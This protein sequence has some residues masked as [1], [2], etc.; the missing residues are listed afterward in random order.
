MTTPEIVAP[1]FIIGCHRSGTSI[2]Y[3]K[4]ALHPDLAFITRTTRRAPNRLLMMRLF[5]LLRSKEKNNMPIG[6]EVWNIFGSTDDQ[7]MT[8][9][10]V[11]P[12]IR[13]YFERLV[14]NHLVLFKRQRFFNK[15]PS[16]SVKIGFLNALF[17]DACF[18]HMVRDGR[19]VARSISK[20]RKSHGRFS[21]AKIPGW[22]GLLDRPVVESCGLQWKQTIEYIK[23]SLKKIP[24]G[25]VL[26]VR[27][28]D[29]IS[30]PIDTMRRVGE[31]CHLEWTDP[32]LQ[33]VAE[34]L[35]SRNYK[36]SESFSPS[37]IELLQNLQGDLLAEL[38]YTV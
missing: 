18:I 14:K 4:L 37:E 2:F 9:A 31:M 3:R 17:P 6:G 22:Q 35:R 33:Q 15:S 29:F 5:M 28:E 19:A 27:Y 8:A 20:G 21:G 10:D 11:T 26:Q 7:V 12:E 36:W 16:N 32:L 30:R 38:G 13:E 34:G 23:D 1:I 25:R 24:A